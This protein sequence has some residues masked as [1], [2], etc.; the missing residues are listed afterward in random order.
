M[1]VKKKTQTIFICACSSHAQIT[2]RGN[3][4][5]ISFRWTSAHTA[6][7]LCGVW[8][9]Y[10]TRPNVMCIENNK[11]ERRNKIYVYAF[12]HAALNENTGHS[13]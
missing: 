4:T 10:E 1:Q 11:A 3:S 12:E 6:L 13:N 8:R 2:I 9:E 5:E 7:V